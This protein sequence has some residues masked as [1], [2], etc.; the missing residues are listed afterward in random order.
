MRVYKDSKCPECIICLFFLCACHWVQFFRSGY[1][2]QAAVR[3]ICAGTVLIFT[4]FSGSRFWNPL[5]LLWAVAILFWNRFHNYTSFILVLISISIEP[6][7]KKP[8]LLIY[9]ALTFCAMYIYKDSY[10]HL[11]IHGIG[12]AFFYTVFDRVNRLILL[13]RNELSFIHSKNRELIKEIEELK[14]YK[15][16]EL[17]LTQEERDILEELCNGKEVKEIDIYSQNTV[18]VKIREARKRNNCLTNDELKSRFLSEKN[19]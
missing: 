9:A 2:I 8:Y 19:Q 6:K 7:T 1:N 3:E 4:I 17:N 12:C 5:L 11:V 16:K 18:Y 10:T 15:K 14:K 13:Y